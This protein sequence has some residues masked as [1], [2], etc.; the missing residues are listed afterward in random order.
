[1]AVGPLEE[2]FLAV[3]KKNGHVFHSKT[4]RSKKS[5]LFSYLTSVFKDVFSHDRLR[6]IPKFNERFCAE[7]NTLSSSCHF[8]ILKWNLNMKMMMCESRS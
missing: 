4:L 1:M 8:L 3:N 7:K 2:Y 5:L 6:E